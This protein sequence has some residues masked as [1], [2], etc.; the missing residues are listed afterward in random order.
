[1]RPKNIVVC[2]DG[3]GQE[4]DVRRTNVVRLYDVLDRSDPEQ[5][6]DYYHPGIGT[7]PATGALTS[8]T[9]TVTRWAGLL[10]GYGLLDIVAKAY[11]FIVDH[12]GPG[13]RST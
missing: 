8:V 12:Y 10:A 9:R 3:T 7:M 6:V 1:M 13:T 5:Q 4:L 11:G 2:C